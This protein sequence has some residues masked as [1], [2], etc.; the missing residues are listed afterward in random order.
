[1]QL[2][3]ELDDAGLCPE[4]VELLWELY[5]KARASQEQQREA[6]AAALAEADDLQQPAAPAASQV[7]FR[8][9]CMAAAG[10]Q[11]QNVKICQPQNLNCSTDMLL[12]TNGQSE[13]EAVQTASLKPTS[14]TCASRFKTS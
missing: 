10:A 6:P 13:D 1:M 9:C 5:E 3:T 8:P 2:R 11:V 4:R 12:L 14:H 7:C